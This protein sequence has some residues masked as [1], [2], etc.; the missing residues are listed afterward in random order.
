MEENNLVSIYAQLVA[1][2]NNLPEGRKVHRRYI[3]EYHR[4]LRA[5]NTEVN[6]NISDFLIN[7]RH[8]DHIAGVSYEDHF[9]PWGDKHC[10]KSFLLSKLDAILMFFELNQ[11]EV[12]I[13][14]H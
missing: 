3:D 9:Q 14:F 6:F 7:E 2:K 1:L 8:F 4:L 13:G 5:L 12:S 11:K 10:D